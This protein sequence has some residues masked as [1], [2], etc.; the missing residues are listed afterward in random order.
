MINFSKIIYKFLLVTFCSLTL[1]ASE[2]TA[3]AQEGKILFDNVSC[4]KCHISDG[5]FDKMNNKV[6]NIQNLASWVSTCDNSLHIGWFP[7]EQEKVTK[8]LNETYYKLKN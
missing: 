6:K 5:D 7:E 3:E 1:H 4:K 8:Y 2:L